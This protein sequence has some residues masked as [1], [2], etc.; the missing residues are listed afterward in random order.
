MKKWMLVYDTYCRAVEK[1]FAVVQPYLDYSLVCS[2]KENDTWNIIKL[3][4]DPAIEGFK[5]N[6]SESDGETQR[7]EITGQD[8]IHLLYGVVDFK[9]IYLPYARD[10]GQHNPIYYFH[11]LFSQPMKPYHYAT[12]ARIKERGIW[13]W[14]Y[15]MYDYR[16]FID[17]MT[18]LKLNTLI[19]WNDCLPINISEVIS[20][21]HANGVCVYLGYSWGW[22]DAQGDQ[23]SELVIPSSIAR[24]SDDIVKEYEEKYAAL[25]CDGIYFQS[26]TEHATDTVNGIVVAQAVVDLVNQTACRL[27][28]NHANLKLLFGLHASSVTNRLDVIQTVDPRVSII[29]E[30]VG[31]FPYHYS[32]DRIDT[33][34]QT[35]ALNSRL[36]DLRQNGGFGAV[37][38]GVICLDWSSF[39]HLKGDYILGVAEQ[40]YIN[41]RTEKQKEILRYIQ[42]YWIRNAKYPHDLIQ[43]FHEDAMIT[44]LVEDGMFENLI[45]YPMALYA[46]M[47]WDSNRSTED[48]MCQTALMP[49]VDFV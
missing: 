16:C 27:L 22:D 12:K 36:Q 47:L 8:E 1:M 29:W 21:A 35:L 39:E 13:L 4:T 24:L 3:S 46:Q 33:F 41:R 48:I 44:C 11:P 15:T 19:I 30:D 28:E 34:D 9:N 42:A 31:A 6:V 26:F 17:N 23:L 18:E 45:N 7:I 25:N 5:I 2:T 38:K 14:G 20:Y 43:Q 40:D 37:L 32:P 49:C 10:A